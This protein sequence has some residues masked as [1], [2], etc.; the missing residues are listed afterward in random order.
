[1]ISCGF[2]AQWPRG[3][4]EGMPH[5]LPYC[6]NQALV[7]EICE[8][9]RMKVS[10]PWQG[11]RQSLVRHYGN[12]PVHLQGL[13]YCRMNGVPIIP[14]SPAQHCPRLPVSW[15]MSVWAAHHRGSA[16]FHLSLPQEE[17][18][19][20]LPLPKQLLS[21]F[22][23]GLLFQSWEPQRCQIKLFRCF[24]KS[25]WGWAELLKIRH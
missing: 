4:W 3:M 6:L 7:G 9:M 18:E 8:L 24:Y 21:W 2:T 5:C 16:S 11:S 20:L 10:Q 25:L 13:I 15:W 1:M 14:A 23:S 19:V 17:E 12:F 22:A